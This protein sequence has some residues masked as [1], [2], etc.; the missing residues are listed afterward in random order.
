MRKRHRARTLSFLLLLGPGVAAA[1]DGALDAGQAAGLLAG[2]TWA[3]TSSAGDPYWFWHAGGPEGGSFAARFQKSGE[4]ARDH[5]GTWARRGGQL[6]WTWPSYN[7][8][9]ICYV[10][11]RLDEGRLT[12]VRDD[13]KVHSGQLTPGN[14]ENLVP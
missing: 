5:A 13:G 6:C 9:T 3:G 11:F 1:A 8:K 10:E 14:S 2:Q 4:G 7:D 12:M